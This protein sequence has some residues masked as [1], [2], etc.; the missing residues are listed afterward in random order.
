MWY[1]RMRHC[2]VWNGTQRRDSRSGS[3]S[4][5]RRS[6]HMPF[7]LRQLLTRN[8]IDK[9]IK[10]VAFSECTRNIA[11][12]QRAPLVFFCNDPRSH[13]EFCNKDVAALCKQ[14]RRFCRDH[15]DVWIGFH[16]LFDACEWQMVEFVVVLFGL[17][18]DD[19]V[20]PVGVQYVAKRRAE[21]LRDLSC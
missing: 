9:K 3:S 8:D 4:G 18:L 17:E 1:S 2:R 6:F 12:L 13:C 14:Y 10:H 16:D 21:T 5:G 19:L 7:L 15:L 11:P 20:L